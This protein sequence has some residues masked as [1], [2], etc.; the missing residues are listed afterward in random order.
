M[1]AISVALTATAHVTTDQSNSISVNI[2]Y[3]QDLVLS[4]FALF[5]RAICSLAGE[6]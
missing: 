6:N 3:F 2:W 4:G 1:A 5:G